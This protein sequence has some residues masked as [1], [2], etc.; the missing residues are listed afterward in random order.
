MKFLRLF[1]YPGHKS[2]VHV[3]LSVIFC[4]LGSLI[5]IPLHSDQVITM[6]WI[7]LLFSVALF[8]IYPAL[9]GLLISVLFLYGFMPEYAAQNQ[10]A[11]EM[12]Y[13][14]RAFSLCFSAL[15]L[16]YLK[17]RIPPYSLKLRFIFLFACSPILLGAGCIRSRFDFIMAA[18]VVIVSLLGFVKSKVLGNYLLY[19][20]TAWL[21][22]YIFLLVS[23]WFTGIDS[24]AA[25]MFCLFFE[26]NY[27]IKFPVFILELMI[28]AHLWIAIKP[29]A[30]DNQ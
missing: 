8:S 20:M 11:N 23:G 9:L 30:P 2:N 24:G 28:M 12:S 7:A 27:L 18:G 16:Q 6:Q 17:N 5:Q 29:P 13:P 4:L 19:P 14:I 15:I 26:R 22:G 25:G 3:I 1:S 21:S 10:A